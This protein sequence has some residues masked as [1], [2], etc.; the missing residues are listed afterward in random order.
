[1]ADDNTSVL[2]LGSAVD[3]LRNELRKVKHTLHRLQADTSNARLQPQRNMFFMA[4]TV[5]TI[6]AMSGDTVGTGEVDIYRRGTSDYVTKIGPQYKVYNAVATS[7]AR[8]S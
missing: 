8:P 2:W 4:K 3:Q 7:I 6:T 1:M 5:S